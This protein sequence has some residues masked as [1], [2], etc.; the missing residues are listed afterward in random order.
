MKKSL[1]VALL[2]LIASA[3]ILLTAQNAGNTGTATYA[4]TVFTNVSTASAT[5]AVFRNI[6]QSAHYLTYCMGGIGNF[7]ATMFLEESFDA[8][9]WVT[10]GSANISSQTLL[11]QCSVLQAGG[12]YQN[13]R[14]RIANNS[15]GTINAWYQATSGPI[16]F[17]PSGMNTTGASAP[18]TCDQQI[19]GTLASGAITQIVAGVLTQYIAVCSITV[20]LDGAAGAGIVEFYEPPSLGCNTIPTTSILAFDTT[21]NTPQLSTFGSGVGT[22]AKGI[23]SAQL[24]G[25]QTTGVTLRYSI[26]YAQI[27]S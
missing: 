20:S 12:Y 7:T 9:T 10:I 1:K 26:S 8:V 6:G 24:C 27:Q 22:I 13:V 19:T 16:S 17:A 11:A 18:I 5:S 4:T 14:A 3:V 25:N 15:G 21:A 2:A 23:V